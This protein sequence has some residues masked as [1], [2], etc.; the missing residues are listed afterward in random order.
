MYSSDPWTKYLR[1]MLSVIHLIVSN[2][3]LVLMII[4]TM[5]IITII[6]III[7]SVTFPSF[8]T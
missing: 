1:I 3:L 8:S 4:I 2:D 7:I 6:V 5:I